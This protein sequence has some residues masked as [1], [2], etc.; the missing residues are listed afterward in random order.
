MRKSKTFANNVQIL[1][2]K[3]L[4]LFR[5]GYYI[6]IW[7]HRVSVAPISQTSLQL[8]ESGSRDLVSGGGAGGH[9]PPPQFEVG[10]YNMIPPHVLPSSHKDV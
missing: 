1:Q 2:P 9:V 10:G 5:Y 7:V 6:F 4:Q 3:P 8:R